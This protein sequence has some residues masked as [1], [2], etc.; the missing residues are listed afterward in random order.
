MGGVLGA[1]VT[2]LRSKGAAAALVLATL[3]TTLIWMSVN[4]SL[5][6]TVRRVVTYVD[7]PPPKG[8]E[9]LG[10]ACRYL[11]LV[12]EDSDRPDAAAAM[13]ARAATLVP[14]ESNLV[15]W[16]GFEVKRG[17]LREAQRIYRIMSE[18]L[19]TEAAWLALARCSAALRDSAET[20]RAVAHVLDLHPGN[21]EAIS[22][23]E[24]FHRE[25][26]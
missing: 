22:L 16:S 9:P 1:L 17:N 24:R 11:G 25:G 26:R 6:R 23:A 7:Q 13:F 3:G 12:Y 21:P 19:G 10:L 14:S 2:R 5:E 4:A 20:D 18:R 15:L 8:A